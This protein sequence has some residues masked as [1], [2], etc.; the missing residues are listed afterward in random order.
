MRLNKTWNS[1]LST[2]G[3]A[4]TTVGRYALIVLA[5]L[6]GAHVVW[7]FVF[8]NPVDT[9]TPA[10][11]VVNKAA[12]V[13]AFA[14]DYITTWLT[15]TA[16]NSAALTQFVSVDARDLTLPSTPA[17]VISS[18]T[19]VAVTFEGVAAKDGSCEVFS[20]VV[21][22]NER[23]YES[24][25]PTRA[26]YRVPVLWSAFGPRAASLPDRVE[27]PGPGA[28][29]PMAYPAA[30]AASD[31]AFAVVSGF[32]SAYLTADGAVGRYVTSDSRL[33]GLGGVYQHQTDAQGHAIPLVTGV[34]ATATPAA[35]PDEGQTVRVLAQVRAV[36]SQYALVHLVYPL[37]LRGVGGH[38][39]VAAIDRAPVMS[40]VDDLAPVVPTAQTS[41]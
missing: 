14:Q 20:V 30:L 34:A 25:S 29:L 5:A 21:G 28:D 32:I 22:V 31:P 17:V 13:S 27:G 40:Q 12:V 24:A 1:R 41:R 19:V 10:R 39:S 35:V 4:T 7:E 18:P 15:A 23:A 33:V 3:S 37:T 36:T 16:S 26:L 2:S 38:W 8:G 11:S 6:G 9:V